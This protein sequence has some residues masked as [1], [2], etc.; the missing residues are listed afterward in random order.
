[1]ATIDVVVR[2]GQAPLA[3]SARLGLTLG[4]VAAAFLGAWAVALA[5]SAWFDLANSYVQARETVARGLVFSTWLVL[6]AAPFIVRDPAAFGLRFGLVRRRWREIAALTAGAAVVTWLLL[7]VT[8]AT[9]YSEASLVIET[10]VVPVSEELLFRAVL[11]TLLLGAFARLHGIRLAV[12]LAV[13]V[14]GLAFGTAHLANAATLDLTFVA[15]QA[16]FASVLGVLCAIAMVRA[17]SVLPAMLVH[18][19]VNAVVVLA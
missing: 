11:L 7:R 6:V 13:V 1:M 18:A 4:V 3:R 17:R 12:A 19:A 9:P 15:R 8:G 14:N 10:V 2:A 5:N 16:A